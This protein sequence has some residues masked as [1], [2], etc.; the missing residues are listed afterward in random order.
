LFAHT[1]TADGL[2]LVAVIGLAA[3]LFMILE[4]AVTVL[5]GSALFHY[6]LIHLGAAAGIALAALAIG[7][8]ASWLET[9][10]GRHE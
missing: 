1:S 10:K 8:V 9:R 2:I 6:M 7:L 4:V 5:D 3:A